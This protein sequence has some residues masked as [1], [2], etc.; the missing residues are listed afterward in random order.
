MYELVKSNGAH[1]GYASACK[2]I[3]VSPSGYAA[4]AIRVAQTLDVGLLHAIHEIAKSP[5]YGYRRVAVELRCRGYF[6]NHKRVLEIMRSEG[7][8]CKKKTFKP[9]TTNS[10]HGFK[11]Y[12]NLVKGL[13]ETGLNQVWVGDITYVWAGEKFAYLATILDRYSRKCLGWALGRTLEATVALRALRQAYACRNGQSLAS[14]IHHTDAGVQ[15][16]CDAYIASLEPHGIRISM[17]EAGDPRENAFAESFNKTVK[18]EEAYLTEYASF[19][20]AEMGLGRFIK[21]YNKKRLHSSIGYRPPDEF[22]ED[23]KIGSVL[24]ACRK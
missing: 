8:T 9:R 22:E 2:S 3:G 19:E 1:V 23:L 14:L 12:P 24:T 20:E 11:K 16:A 17:N 4:W 21:W 6:V 7:L 5:R 10:N 13:Q 18:Y 15:Y